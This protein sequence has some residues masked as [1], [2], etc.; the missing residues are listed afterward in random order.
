MTEKIVFYLLPVVAGILI[1][2]L[3]SLLM[4]VVEDDVAVVLYKT[5]PVLY[6]IIPMIALVLLGAVAFSFR[7]YQNMAALQEERAEKII[8]EN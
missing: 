2:V 7:I 5:H 6:L 4:V 8:L 1:D 3:V